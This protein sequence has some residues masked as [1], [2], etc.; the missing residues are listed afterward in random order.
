MGSIETTV[1]NVPAP[2]NPKTSYL[3]AVSA[4]EKLRGIGADVDVGT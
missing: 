2:T 3:A 4:I 1:Q